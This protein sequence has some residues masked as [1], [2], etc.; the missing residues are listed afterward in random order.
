MSPSSSH[1]YSVRTLLG[2]DEPSIHVFGRAIASHLVFPPDVPLLLALG[3][4]SPDP[5]LIPQLLK[6]LKSLEE[7]WTAANN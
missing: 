1:T 2:K 5:A 4:N 6:E 3:L 7:N